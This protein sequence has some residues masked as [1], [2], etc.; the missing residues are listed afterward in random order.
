MKKLLIFSE[1]NS[2]PAQSF[3]A[4]VPKCIQ[5]YALLDHELFKDTSL[6]HF[7]VPEPADSR[8]SRKFIESQNDQTN[9]LQLWI[10]KVEMEQ[11]GINKSDVLIVGSFH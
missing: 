11:S 3:F 6:S 7:C 9:D 10:Y 2:T 5:L 1:L 8:H 4:I